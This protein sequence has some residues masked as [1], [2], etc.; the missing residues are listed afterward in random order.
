MRER[1]SPASYSILDLMMALGAL[2]L[3]ASLAIPF[4][5]ARTDATLDNA[6]AL[7]ARDIRDAQD[8]AAFGRRTL[9]MVFDAQG[10]GYEV[11]DADGRVA[12]TPLGGE[13]FRRR[14]SRDAVFRG[15]RISGVQADTPAAIHFRPS[16][17]VTSAGSVVIELRGERRLLEL[18]QGGGR[19][20]IE[21][22]SKPWLD[23]G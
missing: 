1:R 8:L 10:D 18:E 16:G 3:F 23:G 19:I 11:V 7:L 5:F 14:Y 12:S 4:W 20:R 13:D 22:M 9:R 21:G 15:V 17:F 2:A 6:A